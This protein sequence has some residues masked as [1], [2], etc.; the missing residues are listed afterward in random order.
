MAWNR[1]VEENDIPKEAQM[2]RI[3]LIVNHPSYDPS[4]SKVA[5]DIALI[6]LVEETSWND[7]I[8]PVCLPDSVTSTSESFDG[9]TATVA[10]WGMLKSGT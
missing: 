2:Y 1:G 7:L 8:Q 4:R 3:N 5:H 6:N 9:M 10:G